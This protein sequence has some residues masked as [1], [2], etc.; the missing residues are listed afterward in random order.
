MINITPSGFIGYHIG[1][2]Y[3]SVSPS[4]FGE[5]LKNQKSNIKNQISNH[6]RYQKSN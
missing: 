6:R 4:G 2:G 1:L 5:S 3:Y